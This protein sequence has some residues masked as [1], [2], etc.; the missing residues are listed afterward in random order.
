MFSFVQKVYRALKVIMYITESAPV[1]AL[2]T[3]GSLP[4]SLQ[5]LNLMH[6]RRRSRDCHGDLSKLHV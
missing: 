1:A 5:R 6:R 2:P 3:V 4:M